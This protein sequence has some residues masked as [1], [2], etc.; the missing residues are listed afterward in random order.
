MKLF[1]VLAILSVSALA[2]AGYLPF[3][4]DF[5]HDSSYTVVTQHSATL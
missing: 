4:H 2:N 3:Q 1:V 5:G